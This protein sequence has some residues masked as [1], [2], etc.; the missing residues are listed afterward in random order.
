MLL[1]L[2]LLVT[3]SIF[4]FVLYKYKHN[5]LIGNKYYYY[6]SAVINTLIKQCKIR[7]RNYIVENYINESFKLVRHPGYIHISYI[8]DGEDKCLYIPLRSENAFMAMQCEANIIYDKAHGAELKQDTDIP[9]MVTPHDLGA[10]HVQVYNTFTSEER[11]YKGDDNI[12]YF[13]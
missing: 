12:E 11:I 4:T 8:E 7:F 3:G 9:I 1:L 13:L 6:V 2:L 10:K 5:K